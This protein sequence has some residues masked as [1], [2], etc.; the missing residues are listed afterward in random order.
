M[1]ALPTSRPKMEL[2]NRVTGGGLSASYTFTR[3]ISVMSSRFICVELSFTN[4]SDQP[5]KNLCIANKVSTCTISYA[6]NQFS[7]TQSYASAGTSCGSAYVCPC[8]CL[9]VT[10]RCSI[11]MDGR[12]ELV[13]ACRLLSSYPT[14]CYEIQLSTKRRVL[15]SGTFS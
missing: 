1:G 4:F 2:L 14:L 8:L 15:H 5:V 12:I 13:L 6:L 10:S 3:T 7:P 9:S 11:E